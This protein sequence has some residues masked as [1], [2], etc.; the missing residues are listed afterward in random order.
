M[1]PS[2][3]LVTQADQ[4]GRKLDGTIPSRIK[5]QARIACESLGECSAA[6]GATPGDIVRL[7][8]YYCSQWK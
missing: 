1:V 2:S 6:A 4:T 7:H 3:R 5:E 8:S